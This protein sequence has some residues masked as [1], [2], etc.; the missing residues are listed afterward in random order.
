MKLVAA[1]SLEPVA[2]STKEPTKATK[3]KFCNPTLV[4]ERYNSATT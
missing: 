1:S 2:S 3:G 4:C